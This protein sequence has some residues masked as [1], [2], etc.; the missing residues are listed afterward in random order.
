MGLTKKDRHGIPSHIQNT[1][2][3]ENRFDLCIM[4]IRFSGFFC[5]IFPASRVIPNYWAGCGSFKTTP[6]RLFNQSEMGSFVLASRVWS[7]PGHFPIG[8]VRRVVALL[9]LLQMETPVR[10]KIAAD[11]QRPQA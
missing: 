2:R 1:K 11:P 7:L 5:P 3:D 10:L 8:I 4:V 9:F 6:P